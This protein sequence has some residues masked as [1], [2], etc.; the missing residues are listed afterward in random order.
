[1]SSR[2]HALAA[3]LVERELVPIDAVA[4]V[5]AHL[6][7]QPGL[8]PVDNAGDAGEVKDRLARGKILPG[9]HFPDDARTAHR[10]CTNV[11]CEQHK[12]IELVLIQLDIA[13]ALFERQA[14]TFAGLN[15]AAYG[16]YWFDLLSEGHGRS[17]FVRRSTEA[18]CGHVAGDRRLGDRRPTLV[19]YPGD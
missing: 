2:I 19:R 5:G 9:L 16:L 17:I 4:S 8:L 3:Q 7:R 13:E 15:D 10:A 18:V 6:A 14:V 1:M 11:L 12:S